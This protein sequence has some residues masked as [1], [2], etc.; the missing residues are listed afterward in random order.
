MTTCV[1]ALGGNLGDPAA[2]IESALAV[3]GEHSSI[4]VVQASRLVESFALT[5]D[6]I[7][8]SKPN[9]LN[10]VAKLETNLSPNELLAFL[11]SVEA[12]FGRVREE[13]WAS[14]TLDIDIITFGDQVIQT[15]ELV[16]PHPRAHQ[17]GFVLIPW[18]DMDPEAELPGRGRVSELA[19]A[20]TNEV[21]FYEAN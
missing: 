3:I 15:D 17:R 19:K 8:K 13:R 9:Y 6:G 5:T 10:S 7:D 21:W 20:M 2:A 16:I 4:T 1:I 11:N 18:L 12:G 14:R